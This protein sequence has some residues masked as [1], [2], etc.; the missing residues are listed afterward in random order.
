MDCT[1]CDAYSA[2]PKS[3]GRAPIALVQADNICKIKTL[4]EN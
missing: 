4:F 2:I 3:K 1:D